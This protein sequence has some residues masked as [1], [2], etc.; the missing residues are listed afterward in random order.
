MSGTASVG[1][2]PGAERPY[3]E[4]AG[5]GL[6][7]VGVLVELALYLGWNPLRGVR[8][9]VRA[10]IPVFGPA[11]VPSER[12]HVSSSDRPLVVEPAPERI[13]TF[14]RNG[15]PVDLEGEVP[16]GP[17]VKEGPMAFEEGWARDPKNDNDFWNIVEETFSMV[18]YV[19]HEHRVE[20][21][22]EA[23]AGTLRLEGGGTFR[24][25]MADI[26]RYRGVDKDV[27]SR[28]YFL[29]LGRKFLPRV[30]HQIRSRR[31]TPKFAKDWGVVMMCHGF[32]SA[33][34]LD[35]SDGLFHARAARLSAEARNKDPR[36]RW[37]AR[38]ILGFMKPGPRRLIRKQADARLAKEITQLIEKGEF[39]TGFDG[40]WFKSIMDRGALRYAYSQ[41]RL[42][43]AQLQRLA[44]EPSNDIPPINFSR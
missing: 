30:K 18:E 7:L 32:I 11:S 29:S 17:I 25:L 40:S 28:D 33:H 2:R 3:L 24:D 4:A 19:L 8:S 1:A 22:D 35:D 38:Q 6:P 34:I 15:Q 43:L 5:F 9:H 39:P 16:D 31:L 20:T 41:K 12:P 36:K 44:N 42:T 23:L 37:V 13:R 21:R 10:R 26:I 27:D 14:G